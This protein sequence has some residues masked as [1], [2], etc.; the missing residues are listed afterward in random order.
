[1]EQVAVKYLFDETGLVPKYK[2]KLHSVN[3]Y[4]SSFD[5]LSSIITLSLSSC[6]IYEDFPS[7]D[8]LDH[9]EGAD[10]PLSLSFPSLATPVSNIPST[11][12][13][14]DTYSYL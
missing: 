14:E 10:Q 8:H 6:N 11:D 4:K 13:L 2:V 1:M 3:F 5:V 12:F 9:S 7:S